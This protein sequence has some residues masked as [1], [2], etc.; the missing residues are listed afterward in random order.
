MRTYEV[1][2]KISAECEADAREVIEEYIGKETDI[3][4]C[5]I[6]EK[7]EIQESLES[8]RGT[9]KE[10]L[11]LGIHEND[12][13]G[14]WGG[15]YAILSTGEGYTSGMLWTQKEVMNELEAIGKKYDISEVE[16]DIENNELQLLDVE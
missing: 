13:D 15:Y 8:I 9:P 4:I 11:Y 5:S 16:K 7:S 14:S 1:Y 2:L 10:K 12:D 6:E 3:E